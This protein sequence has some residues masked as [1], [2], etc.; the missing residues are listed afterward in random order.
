[1]SV[2]YEAMEDAGQFREIKD[3]NLVTGVFTNVRT[4]TY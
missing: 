3:P 1:M 4:S 2:A